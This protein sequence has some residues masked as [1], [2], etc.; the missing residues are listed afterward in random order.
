MLC[1]AEAD[2]RRRETINYNVSSTYKDSID[3][4]AQTI[5][6]RQIPLYISRTMLLFRSGHAKETASFTT[7]INEITTT[8]KQM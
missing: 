1:S 7:L 8:S 2:T 3:S 4:G 6:F 5:L